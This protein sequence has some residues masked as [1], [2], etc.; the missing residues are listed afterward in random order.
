MNI[1]FILNGEDV[2]IRSEANVRLI[3][4]LRENFGLLGAKNGCLSGKCGCC[5]VFFNSRV[6][7]ACLI[8][9]FAL[10]GSEVITIEGFSQTE[11]YADIVNGF[12][13]AKLETCAFCEAGRILNAGALL[14]R[15][16]RPSRAQIL[17]A[18]N[19]IKCRCTDPDALVLGIEK[20][21]E[22]R[23]RRLYGRST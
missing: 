4:I 19:S 22:I 3:D 7:H 12:N 9:A 1:G 16:K 17:Y 20:A 2:M 11:E 13:Q 18:F 15:I 10:Q 6:S 23:H 14:D 21:I 8:P 5:A